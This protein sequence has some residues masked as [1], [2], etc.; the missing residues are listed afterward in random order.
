M[1][2]NMIKPVIDFNLPSF[3]KSVS[4]KGAKNAIIDLVKDL[5][6]LTFDALKL[7]ERK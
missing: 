6:L 5:A 7:K 2:P 3:V 4:Q 1:D